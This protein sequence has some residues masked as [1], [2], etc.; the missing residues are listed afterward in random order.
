M[1]L[2]C[3][4]W[5]RLRQSAEGGAGEANQGKDSGALRMAG[6]G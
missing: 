1:S 2:S 5:R 3:K 4:A 6:R